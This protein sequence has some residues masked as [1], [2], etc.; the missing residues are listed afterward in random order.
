MFLDFFP[1]IQ[2]EIEREKKKKLEEL[3]KISRKA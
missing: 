2:G 1:A 3:S